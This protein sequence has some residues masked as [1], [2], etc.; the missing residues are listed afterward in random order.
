MTTQPLPAGPT[1]A[2][3]QTNI[4]G[5]VTQSGG[6]FNTGIYN[7]YN[8]PA[9]GTPTRAPVPLDVALARLA[10]LPTDHVPPVAALP[11]GSWLPW[12]ANPYF[13]GRQPELLALARA[14]KGGQTAGIL[15]GPTIAATGLGGIG[16]TQLAAAFAHHYGAYFL[17]G[18]Y[19]LSFADPAAIA[20][21]VAQCA[22]W[23]SD[24]PLG[25]THLPLPDQI[26]MV[27]RAWH[28]P[29]PRLLIFD[30]CE[31]PALLKTWRPA[32]GGCHIIVTSRR[33]RWSGSQGVTP[34]PLDTLPREES[35][36]LLRK[37]TPS[38]TLPQGGE[39]GIRDTENSQRGGTTPSSNLG[40]GWGG[41]ILD[42]IAA[43]LGDL[44][45][46]LHMAGSYLA[47]VAYDL[48][49]AAYL[50]ALRRPGLLDHLSLTG[51]D[52][53]PTGHE[54]H[55]ARTFALSYARLDD[56]NAT[57]ATARHILACAACFAPGEAIPRPLLRAAADLGAEEAAEHA[58]DALTRLVNLGLIEEVT[59]G[60][61]R[62]HRLLQH[63]VASAL[64]NTLRAAQGA[65]ETTVLDQANRLDNASDPSPLLAWQPHLRHI[66]DRAYDR[67]DKTAAGLC[68]T[69]GF[70]LQMIDDYAGARSYWERALAIDEQVFGA[71]H[72]ATAHSLNNLGYLL[73]AIGDYAG[74]R[75]H[76]ERALA[77][78]Q[79]VLGIDELD[80]ANS[81]NSL[82]T[83]LQITGDYAE[84]RLHYERA[85]AIRQQVLGIDHPA[86]AR[87]L[88]NL[89]QL[90]HV[91]GDYAGALTYL[92]RAL[93]I[94]EQLLG[95][96]HPTTAL[97]LNN[98]GELLRVMGDYVGAQP[99]YERALS[100]CEHA[101]GH[102][103]H[104]T[105]SS[106]NNLGLVLQAT[107]NNA[108]ARTYFERALSIHEQVLGF[109][110]PS[111]A[112]SLNNLGYLLRAI[113][114][115]AEAQRYLER[116]LSIH[117]QVLGP[118]HPTTAL[119]LNNLG[120]MLQEKGDYAEARLYYER[121]LPIFEQLLGAD[122]PA[123][124]TN[125]NNLGTL[126]ADEGNIDAAH[127]YL[128]QALSIYE[129][130]LGADHPDT[131]RARKNLAAIHAELSSLSSP[132]PT[133][134]PTLTDRLRT[135]WQR[136][137]RR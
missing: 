81:F 45:L 101:L 85:L 25:V 50:A 99:Y 21:E 67:H 54:L 30:N 97:S 40:E 39:G 91:I 83:L 46:A 51:A 74:A 103:H 38:P 15:P 62:L 125:L 61:L 3:P 52:Y 59:D 82:G 12:P 18:V 22:A 10:E 127:T 121:S 19:W 123:I 13:V 55:V 28:E 76:Y 111:T 8:F 118:D 77:T 135:T 84:A 124:A 71:N 66:T 131:Q 114:D 130:R 129:L 105:A 17:G 87:S 88:N 117:E 41:G 31:E 73:Q 32:S 109:D 44:P 65:V 106:L 128:Q 95:S 80:M 58:A 49:P 20:S 78:R 27:R 113:G 68:N 60:A 107:G 70:H 133:F 16:K 6:L 57:D 64:T 108:G 122:H 23:M 26:Q 75:L 112:T 56:T 86:T 36:A 134:K 43:A 1:I 94:N 92:E 2:G 132:V 137:W 69:L 136:M 63:F 14:L 119:S 33:A 5:G 24:L 89:G 79:Q 100:I 126:A 93:S 7:Q 35:I 4:T 116:A 48:P 104:Y 72:P 47:H 110:H 90:L 42:A 120:V 53:S 11:A 34:I 102:H 96:D 115:Y 98:L 37:F 9:A 29:L